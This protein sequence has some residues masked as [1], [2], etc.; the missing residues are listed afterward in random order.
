MKPS[1]YAEAVRAYQTKTSSDMIAIGLKE[2]GNPSTDAAVVTFFVS[3]KRPRKGARR[4]FADGTWIVPKRIRMGK[5]SI[6][7]NVIEVRGT[8]GQPE[9]QAGA[10]SGPTA[11]IRWLG[12]SSAV[13]SGTERGAVTCLVR[14]REGA[15]Y[16]VLTAGHVSGAPNSILSA[17]GRVIGNVEA[18]YPPVQDERVYPFWDKPNGYFDMDFGMAKVQDAAQWKMFLQ[19][20]PVCDDVTSIFNPGATSFE[21]M[22]R[23]Y[24]GMIIESVSTKEPSK[25]CKARIDS[26]FPARMDARGNVIFF[27]FGATSIDGWLGVKGESGK[28]WVRVG[29][30]NALIGLH[31]GLRKGSI[32]LISDIVPIL[33]LTGMRFVGTLPN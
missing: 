8:D 16:Y 6:G 22:K 23:S 24:V 30:T 10:A 19:Y 15:P 25:K 5:G 32:A 26:I 3:K 9:L 27:S 2:P 33:R 11:P 29:E 1:H 4:T 31:V 18:A 14:K 20:P 13:T 12:P 17:G 21:A 28:P 7:T